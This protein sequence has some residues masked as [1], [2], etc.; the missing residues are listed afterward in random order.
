MTRLVVVFLLLAGAASA[1]AQLVKGRLEW[2]HTVELRFMEDGVLSDVPVLAGQQVETGDLLAV[3]D[4]REFEYN[5]AEAAARVVRAEAALAR[6]ERQLEW[7]AELYDRGLISENERLESEEHAA[8]ARAEH[9][10]TKAGL[11]RAEVALE[12]TVLKAPFD[13]VVVSVNAWP[14]QTVVKQ[15]QRDPLITLA[16]ARQMVVRVRMTADNM[17][18]FVPGQ[19]VEVRVGDT[20]WR[21]ARVYRLGVESE[22]V[23]DRGVVYGLD[24]LFE[25]WPDE[26][27]RP[28]QFA[29]VR[30]AP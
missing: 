25:T 13:G 7:T 11:G 28:G 27:L 4:P 6:A 29:A 26:S 17:Q 2:A 3:L 18:A 20:G 21:K 16:D 10:S 23:I 14:G 15:L 19:P 8:T 5:R 24:V 22:D 12:R 9:E 30:L 1:A